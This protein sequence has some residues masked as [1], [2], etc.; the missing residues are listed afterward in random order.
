MLADIIHQILVYLEVVRTLNFIGM[1]AVQDIDVL[2]L[3]LAHLANSRVLYRPISGVSTEYFPTSLIQA[4]VFVCF[5]HCI[6]FGAEEIL[7]V[8]WHG[9]LNYLDDR[10]VISETVRKF[11]LSELFW[12][13]NFHAFL[14][15]HRKQL[16]G[17]F[18]LVLD[19]SYIQNMFDAFQSLD[20]AKFLID[21]KLLRF[22]HSCIEKL[23]LCPFRVHSE[24]FIITIDDSIFK[25]V[26]TLVLRINFFHNGQRLSIHTIL[27]MLNLFNASDLNGYRFVIVFYRLLCVYLFEA[28][29]EISFKIL[30]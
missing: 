7:F 3:H 13:V 4:L 21:Q 28:Q 15:P 25:Q 5:Q 24:T 9:F 8:P 10:V 16:L 14:D 22:L 29:F 20:E 18:D 12:D 11:V 23:L 27:N 2:S 19:H 1:Y 26:F 6:K 30:F 17:N